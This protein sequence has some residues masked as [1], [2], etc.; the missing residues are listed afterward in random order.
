MKQNKLHNRHDS[1]TEKFYYG[2]VQIFLLWKY[3]VLHWRDFLVGLFSIKLKVAKT[4]PNFEEL[5]FR[6]ISKNNAVK[7][8][9]PHNRWKPTYSARRGG[10]GTVW[11]NMFYADISRTLGKV[12]I[13][14]EGNKILKHLH[15]TFVLCSSARTSFRNGL[16]THTD[17][18]K[19][20][21]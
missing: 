7:K 12:H 2:A 6:I 19:I 18:L 16:D 3:H 21:N 20:W 13:F 11:R 17:F 14:W 9:I 15:L 1:N 10:G 4:Q 5:L 8:S